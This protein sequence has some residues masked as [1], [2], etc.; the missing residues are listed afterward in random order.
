MR[1]LRRS[2]EAPDG[3]PWSV[4]R[5][6][7][8]NFN[9]RKRSPGS[10]SCRA[11]RRFA[12]NRF[13]LQAGLISA[14][15]FSRG[16]TS[17]AT[18][19]ALRQAQALI[20]RAERLGEL[21]DDPQSL[22]TVLE[23]F[24]YVNH[25]APSGGAALEIAQ[26]YLAL[27]Q[28]HATLAA[29]IVGHRMVGEASMFVGNILASRAHYDQAIALYD[30]AKDHKRTKWGGV[31]WV[32]SMSLRALP[33]WI[34]GYPVAAQSGAAEALSI[35]RNV[36]HA[37]AVGVALL[38]ATRTHLFCGQMSTAR[39]EADEFVVLADET[40]EPYFKALGLMFQGLVYASGAE[41]PGRRRSARILRSAPT[42]RPKRLCSRQTYCRTLQK[43]TPVLGN[44]TMPGAALTTQSRPSKR[45]RNVGAKPTLF[46]SQGK[47]RWGRPNATPRRLRP[48][49]TA[50]S[51]LRG[52]S[53]RNPGN[54]ARRPA[55]RAS[56][57]IN[58]DARRLKTCLRP[59]TPGSPRA[60]T[61]ST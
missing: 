15:M 61:R 23:G 57:A 47:L 39:A 45:A 19:C 5:W 16:Y 7:R 20:D 36:R 10:P 28:K 33:L 50:P 13:E 44:S 53:R 30:P 29:L 22:Y 40:G 60:S 58:A 27:A 4:P 55:R 9:F 56:Y 18:K 43:R 24:F 59:S 26:R 35:A 32:G 6:R 51:R 2:G 14:M 11:R 49:S 25:I 3:S 37:V 54:C 42:G 31:Y 17:A 21:V 41:F 46:A 8:R 52:L 1:K 12:A 38:C 34:L 48:I